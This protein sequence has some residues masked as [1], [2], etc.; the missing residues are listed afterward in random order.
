MHE[1][2]RRINEASIISTERRLRMLDESAI[3]L[4]IYSIFF[5]KIATVIIRP[6]NS[7]PQEG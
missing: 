1:R 5:S 6:S 4:E 7:P 2:I 3:Y